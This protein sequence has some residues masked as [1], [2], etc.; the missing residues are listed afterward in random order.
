VV[1]VTIVG[2]NF[3]KIHAERQGPIKGKI[4]I[5]NKVSVKNVESADLALGKSKQQGVKFTFNYL[6]KYEPKVGTVELEGDL[7]YLTDEKGAKSITD[8]WKK[9][10]KL[11]QDI[12][13]SIL[14]TV[15]TKCNLQALISSRDINLPPMVPLPKVQVK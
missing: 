11:P 15:L 12:M 4:N 13:G 5:Q 7:L 1:N 9:N 2:F 3:T 6:S 14:N 10:K 8:E